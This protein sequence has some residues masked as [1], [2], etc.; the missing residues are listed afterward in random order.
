M[1][2]QTELELTI[3]QWQK[4]V[5]AETSDLIKAGWLPRDAAGLAELKVAERRREAH[6][7]K[8]GG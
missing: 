4:E 1:Y 6:A 2:T 5:D 7:D 8:S 3:T